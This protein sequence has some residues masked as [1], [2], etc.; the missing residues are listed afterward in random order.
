MKTTIYIEGGGD[1][2]SLHSELRQGFQSLFKS[3]GFT[4]RLP[5]VVAC[6]SRNDAFGD[7]KTGYL[8]KSKD[9]AILLLVDSEEKVNKPT[10]WEHVLVRDGW[11]KLPNTTEENL[12]FMV[13]TME[14]WYLADV[15]GIVKF[16]GHGF[17]SSKLPKTSNLEDV[18]KAQLYESLK[19]ATKS[20]SKGVYGKGSHS[21]KILALLDANKVKNHGKHSK[22]FFKYLNEIL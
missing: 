18:D 16:F 11:E 20:S 8:S 3:A 12:F 13:V 17:D 19:K 2:A 4:G 7:F 15:N 10:K 21:F 9:E 5:K 6:G 1:T 14:S 22:E